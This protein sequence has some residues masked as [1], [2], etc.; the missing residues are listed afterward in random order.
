MLHQDHLKF[1]NKLPALVDSK[2]TKVLEVD[3]WNSLTI[4]L[5]S[6]ML[7]AP[8]SLKNEYFLMF[9]KSS[10]MSII[11]VIWQKINTLSLFLLFSFKI[12]SSSLSLEESDIK[13]PKLITSI[14]VFDYWL[15]RIP[16]NYSVILESIFIKSWYFSLYS[17]NKTN[18]WNLLFFISSLSL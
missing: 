13:V 10:K 2:N 1:K 14:Q 4:S 18:F 16:S 8:S 15:R 17:P 9:M 7:Q 11:L 5:L 6:A 3:F 12:L